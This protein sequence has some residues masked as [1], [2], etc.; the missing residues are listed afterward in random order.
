M[1]NLGWF[2]YISLG[3]GILS[4][5]TSVA[6]GMVGSW[7]ASLVSFTFLIL[8]WMVWVTLSLIFV[9]M[10]PNDTKTDLKPREGEC[11]EVMPRT[12]K[13]RVI[14]REPI[15]KYIRTYPERI[16]IRNDKYRVPSEFLEYDYYTLIFWVKI[17]RE[18]IDSPTN[19]YLFAYTS[20]PL[21]RDE[22][23]KHTYP[24]A[25]FLRKNGEKNIIE[26]VIKG[27][28]PCNSTVTSVSVHSG[29]IGWRM[30]SVRWSQK[31]ELIEFDIDAGL[32]RE[33]RVIDELHRPVS[34]SGKDLYVGGW[35]DD[36]DGGISRLRFFNFRI[37]DAHLTDSELKEVYDSE[38][39]DW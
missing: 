21:A 28:D 27:P 18:Y 9:E 15:I 26:L 3:I 23:D 39:P 12:P 13:T 22:N 31:R 11:V 17:E 14:T 29:L 10:K 25:F 30:I 2:D 24:N 16:E 37:W 32:I 8:V 35:S 38:N 19:R 1:R 33:S 7:Y 20:N 5:P 4:L 6:T 36:W 34:I